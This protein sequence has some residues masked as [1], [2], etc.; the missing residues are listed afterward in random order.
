MLENSKID[1]FWGEHA[2]ITTNL[3]EKEIATNIR[4]EKFK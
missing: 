3:V 4:E 2:G 1:Q